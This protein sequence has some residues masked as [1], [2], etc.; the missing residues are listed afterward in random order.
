LKT[1]HPPQTWGLVALLAALA[2][3][4][5]AQQPTSAQAGAIR[6]ACRSD[7]QAHCASVPTGGSAAL[8]CLQQNAASL[9]P[10][11]QQAV[12]AVGGGA[13]AFSAYNPSTGSYA[14]GSAVYGPDGAAGNAS[15]YN[16]RTG[17]SD[18][19]NQNANAYGR[20]G[21]STVSGANQTVH[22]QSQSDARGS[23]GSF[24]SSGGA[25]GAAA[26]GA[27]GNSAGAVKTAGGD[28]YAGAEG[29]VYKKT[30]S[31]WQKYDNGSWNS[32]QKPANTPQKSPTTA[33]QR[34]PT[35]PQ[36]APTEGAGATAG[37]GR[38][39]GFDHGA[40]LEQDH[41]ARF[42]GVQRQQSFGAGRGGFAGGL[43]RWPGPGPFVVM[44]QAGLNRRIALHRAGRLAGRSGHA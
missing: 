8:A 43:R 10:G 12:K 24:S 11:C 4:A 37:A 39:Q 3:P 18:T 25:D 30:D 23:A 32:V 44:V 33:L 15:W 41:Q 28:V 31:G 29:N 34:T 17:V 27:G 36:R 26:S 2:A 14:H 38:F 9:S 21:S 42:G 6:Q 5:L 20:W 16:A 19:T 35:A 40:Q 1:P 22:A 13:G 7:Y